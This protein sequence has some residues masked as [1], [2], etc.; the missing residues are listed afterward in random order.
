MRR[1]IL[2]QNCSL[3]GCVAAPDGDLEWVFTGIDPE[4]QRW[5]VAD[6]WNAG[7]HL[8]G[9]RTYGDMAAHWPTSDEPYAPPMNAIPK[10]VFSSSLQEAPWGETRIVAGDLRT[11]IDRLK[12]EDGKDMIAH[13]GA[14]FARSLIRA[15]LVDEYRLFIHPVVVGDGLRIFDVEAPTRFTLVDTKVFARGVVAQTL[16]PL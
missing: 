14:S 12:R 15:G 11:E 10:V 5:A 8:M 13:G 7:L 4:C 6:L 9:S 2:R 16:R 3:D 1:L